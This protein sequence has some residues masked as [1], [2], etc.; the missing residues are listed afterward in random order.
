MN[1]NEA[2]VLGALLTAVTDE[3]YTYRTV[4]G[5]ANKVGLSTDAVSEVIADY[6][7]FFTTATRRSD[8]EALVGL[9]HSTA[10]TEGVKI[11][12][13]ALSALA[14]PDYEYRTLKALAEA[15]G[16]N[17]LPWV[18]EALDE[19]GLFVVKTRRSDGALLVGLTD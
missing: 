5:V 4:K 12:G 1:K 13:A 11:L 6:I 17:D 10:H 15:A 2:K 18:K 3:R 9:D 14:S 8:G 19:S 16:E 7:D